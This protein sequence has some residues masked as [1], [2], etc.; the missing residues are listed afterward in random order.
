MRRR[1]VAAK[2]T[3]FFT[4]VFLMQSV[5]DVASLTAGKGEKKRR[6]KKAGESEHFS[7]PNTQSFLHEY[8]LCRCRKREL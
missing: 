8:A 7:H 5:C 4:H 3:P 6:E 1:L 2:F